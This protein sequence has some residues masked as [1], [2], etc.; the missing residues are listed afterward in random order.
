MAIQNRIKIKQVLS[1]IPANT[2]VTAKQLSDMGVNHVLASQYEKQGWLKRVATGAYTR[3]Q[4][5]APLDGALYALQQGEMPSVHVGGS[6]ALNRYY[7][8]LHFV[9]TNVKTQLFAPLGKRLPAWFNRAYGSETVIGYTNFLPDTLGLETQNTDN[10]M[11]QVSSMERAVLEMLYLTPSRITV[12]EAYAIT[13]T[14]LTV[15]IQQMQK[16]LE[17]CRSI[18]VKRLLLCFAENIGHQWF[19]FLDQS[20]IDLGSGVR[21]IGT[22]GILYPKYN[23]VIPKLGEV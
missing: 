9:R 3:L 15:R 7:G 13:E 1:R 5:D 23:L 22:S 6:S 4:E 8:K 20:R 18:K 21:K 17:E 11:V 10:F 16:L 12:A 2:V 14:V 19:D